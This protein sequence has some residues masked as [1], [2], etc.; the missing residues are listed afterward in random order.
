MTDTQKQSDGAELFEKGKSSIIQTEVDKTPVFIVPKDMKVEALDK[1]IEDRNERPRFLKQTVEALSTESF[2]KYWNQFADAKSAIFTDTEKAKFVGVLDYHEDPKNPRR[3][4]HRIVY[5]CPF[6]KEWR[7]WTSSDNEKM[8]QTEFALFIEDHMKQFSAP[9]GGDMLKVALTLK[10]KTDVEF[11]SGIDL[12]NGE[13]KFAYKETVNGQAGITGELKIPEEFT[14]ALRP[15]QN[16]APYE[17]KARFRY[18][19]GPSG[20][21][22]WYT[23]QQ[24]HLSLEDAV[25]DAYKEIEKGITKGVILKAN[26]SNNS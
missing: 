1:F 25:N 18:R 20:L 8:S 6:T 12:S 14:L 10:S 4:N 24:P 19:K 9:T 16:G 26:L 23:L 11:E 3:K 2:L 15:F 7:D 22:M 5:D 21:T 13:V 17:I